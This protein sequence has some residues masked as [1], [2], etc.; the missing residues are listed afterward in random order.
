MMRFETVFFYGASLTTLFYCHNLKDK[1][2]IIF[3]DNKNI[4]SNFNKNIKIYHSSKIK[5]YNDIIIFS[6]I[7]KKIQK[8]LN[9]FNNNIRFKFL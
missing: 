7:K 3:D 1:K 9:A 6:S 4:K 8:N 2:I 5:N